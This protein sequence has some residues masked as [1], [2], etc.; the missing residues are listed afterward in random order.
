[1]AHEHILIEGIYIKYIHMN[2]QYQMLYIPLCKIHQYTVLHRNIGHPINEETVR[3]SAHFKKS[4]SNS[5]LQKLATPQ[6]YFT[7]LLNSAFYHYFQELLLSASLISRT[8][9]ISG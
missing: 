5:I 8:L 9:K 4:I 1:M 3:I 7:P 6:L 2:K